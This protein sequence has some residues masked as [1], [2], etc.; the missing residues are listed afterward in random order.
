M[1]VSSKRLS[2]LPP[3]S[4]GAAS[5]AE[6]QELIQRF[7]HTDMHIV[8]TGGAGSGK[9]TAALRKA[10]L[11]IERG[12]VHQ[13][14]TALFL[15]FANATIDR[16]A[17]HAGSLL[18]RAAFKKL[19]VSTYHGMAWSI[20]RSHGYL[21]GAPRALAILSPGEQNAFRAGLGAPDADVSGE[22]RRLFI[23]FGQV[24]FDLFAEL[25]ADLLVANPAIARAYSNAHPVIF[26]DEFQDTS[27]SQWDMIQALGAD[28]TLIALGD[29][30]QRIYGHLPGASDRRFDD[31]RDRYAPTEFDLS[32]WNWR[33]PEGAIADFGR[34]ILTGQLLDAYDSVQVL[35]TGY[36]PLSELKWAVLAGLKRVHDSNGTIAILTPTRALSAR[37]Y[38]YFTEAQSAQLPRLSLDINSDKDEAFAAVIF[39]ATLMELTDDSDA[40]IAKTCRAFSRYLLTRSSKLAKSSKELSV[41]ML[42]E[43]TRLETSAVGREPI[44]TSRLRTTVSAH[45]LRARSGHPFADYLTALTIATESEIVELASAGK[46]ARIVRLLTRGSD[47]EGGLSEAW[48]NKGSYEGAA[49]AMRGSVV[50]YQLLNAKQGSRNLVVMNI[51][52]AKGKEFDEVFVYEEQHTP[53]VRQGETDLSAARKNMN[54]AVTRARKRVTILTPARAP[55]ELFR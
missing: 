12:L 32:A 52:R 55:S 18:D 1:S 2:R 47:L 45:L 8:V 6:Y 30:D 13:H 14:S 53:F 49:E 39:T 11:A 33:S 24:S 10:G 9:T 28:S 35:G 7:L 50:Q 37:V 44:A 21:L 29:P 15:S 51:H 22:F 54:V 34:D 41:K 4:D 31:F 43:A 36:Q 38:D 46:N 5:E 27:D 17:E 20:L 40:S 16:V 23:D 25:A 19:Q 3:T 48:R 26:L 42:S